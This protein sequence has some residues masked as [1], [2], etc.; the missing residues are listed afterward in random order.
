MVYFIYVLKFSKYCFCEVRQ[1][2]VGPQIM[3]LIIIVFV[4]HIE[5]YC[6]VV[7][8]LFGIRQLFYVLY[9][10]NFPQERL[11]QRRLCFLRFNN[12]IVLVAGIY[13]SIAIE[14]K[15]CF[16]NVAAISQSKLDM[17]I[18]KVNL[19]SQCIL[20]CSLMFELAE[21]SYWTHGQ[22]RVLC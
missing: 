9:V 6:I 2:F 21:W 7:N 22:S 17:E 19:D 20:V 8:G 11:T 5:C 18:R 15:D 4:Y 12:T 14:P 1:K 13:H 10:T 16:G 3:Y